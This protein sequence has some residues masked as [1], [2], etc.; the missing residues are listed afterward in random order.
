MENKLALPAKTRLAASFDH[1][2]RGVRQRNQLEKWQPRCRI[3]LN[4]S[5][6]KKI[7]STTSYGLRPHVTLAPII[8]KINKNYSFSK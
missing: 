8:K 7:L 4:R 1:A 2:N 3:S 6:I 5:L